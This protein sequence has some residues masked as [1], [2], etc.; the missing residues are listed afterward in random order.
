MAQGAHMT[1]VA[2]ICID[3]ELILFARQQ[4]KWLWVSRSPKSAAASIH[5]V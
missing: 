5:Q 1:R 2:D 4:L 3:A